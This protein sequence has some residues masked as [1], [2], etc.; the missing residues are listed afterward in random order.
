MTVPTLRP[1]AAEEFPAYFR[2][3]SDTFHSDPRDDDREAMFTVFE[4]ERSLAAFDE[5]DVVGTAGI[6][7][8]TMTVPGGQ[9]PIAAV[10]FVSVAPTH[11]RR[12]L[13]TAMMRRQLTDLHEQRREPVAALWASETAIYQRFGYGRGAVGGRLSARTQGLRFRSET[14]TGVGR[15]RL[16]QE[17]E[18]RPRLA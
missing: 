15:V 5:K 16:V 13:L 1:I 4:P 3:L 10:T 6:Y 9:L 2:S 14:D 12:G 18:A 8:R 11:R 7:S 17:E